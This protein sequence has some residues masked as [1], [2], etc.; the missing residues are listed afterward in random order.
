MGEVAAA[1]FVEDLLL[2]TTE[3][4]KKA[5]KY[6]IWEKAIEYDIKEIFA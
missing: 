4:L 5:E 2:H 1:H 3:E 6:W